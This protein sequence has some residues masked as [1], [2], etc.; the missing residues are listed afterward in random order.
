MIIAAER[1]LAVC[2]PLKHNSFTKGRI[3][4]I[5]VLIY[6]MAVLLP[7]I[8]IFEVSCIEGGHTHMEFGYNL[9][10]SEKSRYIAVP[11]RIV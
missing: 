8:A 9:K 5:F 6:I 7:S 11:N 4:L 10:N 1:Y 3:A 2:R